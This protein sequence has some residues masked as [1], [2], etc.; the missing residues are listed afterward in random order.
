MLMPRF[1]ISLQRVLIISFLLFESVAAFG[2]TISGSQPPHTIG[3]R[4]EPPNFETDSVQTPHVSTVS[5]D[6]L[7]HPVSSKGRRLLQ[8][9]MHLADLGDD[10][11]A[12]QGLREALSKEPS[13]APYAFNRLG[14]EYLKINK[15]TEANE[16]LVEAVRLM[17]NESVNHANL[18]ISLALIG[19]IDSAENEERKAL[20]LDRTNTKAQT[21]LAFITSWKKSHRE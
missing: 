3:P 14:L 17:P 10:N 21:L 4:I 8:K 18:G 2:Q 13:T 1:D 12:I 11:A 9:A 20:E 7:R 6:F 16:A 15:Y 19:E 5:A